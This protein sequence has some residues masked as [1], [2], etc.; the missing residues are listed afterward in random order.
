MEELEAGTKE[1]LYYEGAGVEALEKW[2][3]MSEAERAA[4]KSRGDDIDAIPTTDLE[5]Y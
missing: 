2:K 1:K 5:K 4:L 3:A